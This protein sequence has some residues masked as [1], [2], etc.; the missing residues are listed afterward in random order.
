MKANGLKYLWCV[1]GMLIIVSCSPDSYTY[2]DNSTI[3]VSMVDSVSLLPNH[4]MVLADGHACLDLY[5]RLFTKT[6]DSIPDSRVSEDLL[7]YVSSSG[8]AF[9]RYFSTSDAS[10]LG[11]TL[12]VQVKIKGTDVISEPVSFK[13]VAPLDNKYSSEI[14]IP[15]VFHIVQTTKEIESY[16]GQYGADMIALHV[17]KLNNLFGGTVSENPVGVN[18]HIRFELAEYDYSGKKMAEPGIDRFTPE[19]IDNTGNYVEFLEKS[20][21]VWPADKYMNVWLISDLQSEVKDFG[22][23]V[24]DSCQ[25]CYVYSGIPEEG[26]PEGIDWIEYSGET[27][28]AL[29]EIGIV[30]KLQEID[31][32]SRD[33]VWNDGQNYSPINDLVFYV[34][35][36]LGLL[37]TY[38]YG[39]NPVS[40]YCEDTQD[41]VGDKYDNYNNT[42]YK[43]VGSCYFRSENIADDPTGVHVSVSKN[44][45]ERMRWVLENCPQ[46]AAWKSD[47]AFTGK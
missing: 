45:C 1:W 16:G 46:R 29:K 27:I 7:E 5:P 28:F 31:N 26:R 20:R 9:T 42:W 14:R 25:P 30:Y 33:F 37:P 8:V 17:E 24:T 44:Q 36:Y 19:C 4:V 32:Q 47:W 39:D 22:R 15:V 35:R 3:D 38:S 43:T 13:V 2:H 10:L 12:T 18:T 23:N 6:G 11:K 40:D 41:Y 21:L 34:G